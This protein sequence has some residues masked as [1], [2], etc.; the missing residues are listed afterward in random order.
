MVSQKTLSEQDARNRCHQPV[1]VGV[2]S[3]PSDGMA[4]PRADCPMW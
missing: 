3:R 2:G 1:L 4:A